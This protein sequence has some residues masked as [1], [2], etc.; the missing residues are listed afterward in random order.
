MN[1]SMVSTTFAFLSS[2]SM[3]EAS[4]DSLSGT[5]AISSESPLRSTLSKRS[6]MAC[7][8]LLTSCGRVTVRAARCSRQCP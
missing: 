7:S 8:I 2:F 1:T 5:P 4:F 6:S 3:V